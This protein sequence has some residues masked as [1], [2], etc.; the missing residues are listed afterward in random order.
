V[1]DS[2]L[3]PAVS[4]LLD[5]RQWQIRAYAIEALTKIDS[6]EAAS[7]LWPHR[8]EALSSRSDELVIAACRA[9]AKLLP[10]PGLK[11]DA[12]RDRLAALLADPN[13]SATVRQTALE[14]MLAL[15][16]SR[17]APAL[18]LV[19]RDANLEGT[20]LLLEVELAIAKR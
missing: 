8:D 3:V 5:P 10:R 12:V 19:A 11:S 14:S 18:A 1:A 13:A 6:E 4:T 17:L 15:G 7:A 9:A 2:R 20:P 16:D